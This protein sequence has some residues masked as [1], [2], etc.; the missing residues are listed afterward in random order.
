MIDIKFSIVNPA[1]DRFES[2]KC[3]FGNTPFKH[4]HW[5][6]QVMK[7]NDIIAVDF[8]VTTRQ[9]HAGVDLWLG[10]V[11]Y[12]VNFKFYDNR[13]WNHEQGRYCSYSEGESL[14]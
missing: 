11:G 7:D 12:A 5:E 6:I 3:W 4:K 10:L 2:I 14:H 13:H 9:D 8:R 1:S